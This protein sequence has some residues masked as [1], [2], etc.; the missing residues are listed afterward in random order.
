MSYDKA[1]FFGLKM[2]SKVQVMNKS[3]SKSSVKNKVIKYL[4]AVLVQSFTLIYYTTL[5]LVP[6]PGNL[7]INCLVSR[8][9]ELTFV[10]HV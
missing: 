8:S 7:F 10:F 2:G 3:S 6:P 9:R 4:T 1:F 5:S